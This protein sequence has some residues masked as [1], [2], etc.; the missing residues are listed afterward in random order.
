MRYLLLTMLA[1]GCSGL[2]SRRVS[3][4]AEVFASSD[5]LADQTVAALPSAFAALHALPER[6][7]YEHL[8]IEVR[9]GEV[10]TNDGVS[11]TDG[12]ALTLDPELDRVRWAGL[13]FLLAHELAHHYL[14][15]AWHRL[16]A[17]VEEGIADAIGM[18]AEPS[19]VAERLRTYEQAIEATLSSPARRA[20]G[21]AALHARGDQIAALPQEEHL[22]VAAVGF[23]LVDRVGLGG[24]QALVVRAERLGGGPVPLMWVLQAARDRASLASRPVLGGAD[25]LGL[26]EGSY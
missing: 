26:A 12:I 9:H 13:R 19:V 4:P 8:R 17:V 18:E 3:G 20:S 24:L 5:V 1:F 2:P 22:F 10:G 7:E 15:R 11:R 23:L 6:V 25:V 21:L 14:P 16:P